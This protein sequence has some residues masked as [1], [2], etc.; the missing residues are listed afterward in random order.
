MSKQKQMPRRCKGWI[1]VPAFVLGGNIGWHQC[2]ND[3]VWQVTFTRGKK[4]ET[5]PACQWCYDKLLAGED[6]DG[7]KALIARKINEGT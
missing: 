2:A 1:H 3:A 5:L 6:R 7:A 4:K